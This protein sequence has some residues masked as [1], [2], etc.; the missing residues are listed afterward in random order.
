MDVSEKQ[1]NEPVVEDCVVS[2]VAKSIKADEVPV[3]ALFAFKTATN[4]DKTSARRILVLNNSNAT[5][6]LTSTSFTLEN[7]H[8]P[9][10]YLPRYL[11]TDPDDN[12]NS[13][14]ATD[15]T[16]GTFF[17]G[18]GFDKWTVKEG[19]FPMLTTFAGTAYGKLL[20]LPVYSS[21][22]NRLC[23]MNYLL[24]FT[25]GTANWQVTDNSVIE[26]DTDIRVLEP[27]TA[28]S[29]VYLVRSMEDAKIITPIKTAEEITRGIKFED[30]EAK[31]FCLEH[32]DTDHDKAISLQ[33]LKAVTWKQFQEDMKENDGN[34]NDNDGDDI[35]LFPEFRY[36]SGVTAL[37]TSFQE[38]EKLQSLAFSGKINAIPD[39]AFEGNKAMTSFTIPA[40]VTT[41]GSHPFF[42][43]GLQNYYVEPDHPT[44]TATDG[45]LFNK[46]E[47][48]NVQLLSYPNGRKGT[49]VTV[50][51]NVK[52]IA[53]YAIYMMPEVDT[54]YIAAADYDYETVVNLTQNSIKAGKKIKIFI[55]DGTQEL[56]D[57]DDDDDSSAPAFFASRRVGTESG[58]E[59]PQT[60]DGRGEGALLNKYKDRYKNC[61]E[62]DVSDFDRYV[63]IDISANSKAD[64]YYWATLY[65]GFDTQLPDFMTPYIVDKGKTEKT[66][67]KTTLKLRRISNQLR[68]LTPVVIRSTKSGQFKLL[69]SNDNF[70][71]KRIPAYDNLLDGVTRKGLDPHGQESSN[72]GGLLTLGRNKSGKVG[73]FLYKGTTNVPPYRAYIS[74]NTVQY[75][76]SLLLSIDDEEETT[77]VNEE[78]SVENE[79]SA[80]AWYDLK[81]QRVEHPTKGIYIHNGRKVVIK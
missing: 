20:S 14:H 57:S 61:E 1:V 72:Q 53:D 64:G 50:P 25:P 31:K 52:T 4:N 70:R 43:S 68:M 21:N 34:P 55:E 13:R 22:D 51:D 7:C 42:G 69:P 3:N 78:L 73:F 9:K 81:G 77:S 2:V 10:G 27:K 46:D 76:P 66:G 5:S 37:G 79:A 40:S 74:V 49:S 24:D 54:V 33:E 75:S 45:L 8:Y 17:T 18:D 29:Y 65:C 56:G 80:G 44:Y 11:Y 71:Y 35:T 58:A 16:N 36:F 15:M 12:E 39:D 67:N 32:Y 38:K 19:R 30:E 48:G 26:I 62:W 6:K 60:K 23:D 47:D 41:F 63:D 28:N 59:K